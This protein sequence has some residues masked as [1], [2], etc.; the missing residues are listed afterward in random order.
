M[1][2]DKLILES[3][4]TALL[5]CTAI[6]GYPPFHTVSWLK[7][8]RIIAQKEGSVLIIGTDT[9]RPTPYGE[10]S[11]LVNNSVSTVEKVLAVK[12]RGNH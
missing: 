10:Y 11:C 3:N 6:G 4:E 8:G 12:E 5:N 1:Q 7:N 9:V 2:A